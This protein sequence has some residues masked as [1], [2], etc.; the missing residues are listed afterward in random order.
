M[1]KMLIVITIV[2]LMLIGVYFLKFNTAK[3]IPDSAKLVYIKEE[4][5]WL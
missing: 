2:S 4:L 3:K 1:K 5:K